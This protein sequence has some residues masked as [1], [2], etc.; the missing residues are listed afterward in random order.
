MW[1]NLETC[2]VKPGDTCRKHSAVKGELPRKFGIYYV[3]T[4][5]MNLRNI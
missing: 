5:S 3:F 2:K 1:T 4:E